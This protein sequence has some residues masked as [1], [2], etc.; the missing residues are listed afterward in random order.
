MESVS[1]VSQD[2]TT[3]DDQTLSPRLMSL[4]V[5]WFPLRAW[6]TGPAAFFFFFFT[7]YVSFLFYVYESLADWRALSA[8]LCFVFKTKQWHTEKSRGVSEAD[9]HWS[10]DKGVG[11]VIHALMLQSVSEWTTDAFSP[12][13]DRE[14]SQQWFM[15][16]WLQFGYSVFYSQNEYNFHNRSA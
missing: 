7:K 5:V 13:G 15:I 4:T 14:M 12:A 16:V 10:S 6:R 11:Q 3:G 9:A 8:E 1:E 2:K